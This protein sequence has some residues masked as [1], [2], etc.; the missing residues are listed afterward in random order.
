[1]QW[2]SLSVYARPQTYQLLYAVDASGARFHTVV[3]L[4][5]RVKLDEQVGSTVETFLRRNGIDEV[6]RAESISHLAKL[7]DSSTASAPAQRVIVTTIH[8][9]GLLVKDDV[10]LTRLLHRARHDGDSAS[11]SS[12]YSRIAII[13]DEAHRSHTAST[14][15]TIQRV[16]AAGEGSSNAHITVRLPMTLSDASDRLTSSRMRRLCVS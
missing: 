14:R 3:I 9:M 7:M 6:F 8:K 4:I 10:L 13:T 5:D 11:G 15:E 12:D 1:M 2:T 16:I